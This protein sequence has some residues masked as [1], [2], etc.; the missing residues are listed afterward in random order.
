ML[1]LSLSWTAFSRTIFTFVHKKLVAMQVR[2]DS[3]IWWSFDVLLLVAGEVS[4]LAALVLT[5]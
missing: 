3:P 5:L 4:Q 2:L 1:R